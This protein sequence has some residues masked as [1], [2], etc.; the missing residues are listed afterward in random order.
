MPD[1]DDLALAAKSLDRIAKLLALAAVNEKS[2]S[3]QIRLLAAASF[4]TG[5][6][7]SLLGTTSNTVS[8]T[9]SKQKRASSSR[10][11]RSP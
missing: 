1:Q 9:L 7:A 10:A 8:V 4:S 6:I 3:E 11:K 2:Q 5:E